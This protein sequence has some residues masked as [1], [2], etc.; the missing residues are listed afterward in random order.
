MTLSAGTLN[1]NHAGAV[2]TGPFTIAGGSIDNTSGAPVTLNATE[3]LWNSDVTFLGSNPLNLGAGAVSFTD[4][5][6]AE[7]RET[8]EDLIGRDRLATWQQRPR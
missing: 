7:P 4:R 1:L 8:Y 6:F 3:H 2:G 5:P